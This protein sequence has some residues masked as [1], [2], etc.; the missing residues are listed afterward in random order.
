MGPFRVEHADG[1]VDSSMTMPGCTDTEW[2]R[3]TH[4]ENLSLAKTRQV[5]QISSVAASRPLHDRSLK[6]MR[7]PRVIATAVGVL[8]ISASAVFAANP[9]GTTSP[10]V[11]V[12]HDKTAVGGPNNNHGGAVSAVAN[13]TP[14]PSPSPAATPAPSPTPAPSA[15]VP[16]S[17]GA[18]V[19]AVAQDKTAVGGPHN[20]HGGA[21][22]AVAR[23]SHGKGAHGKH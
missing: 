14:S 10:V 6:I 23:G 22:S 15:A 19:S 9:L 16:G 18:A 8:L 17:H 2:Q 12:A 20:N 7:T 5:T 1:L 4:L 13:A 11:T 3:A 21:V